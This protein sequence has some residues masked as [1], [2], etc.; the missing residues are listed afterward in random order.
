MA[1]WRGVEGKRERGLILNDEKI[2]QVWAVY[3]THDKLSSERNNNKNKLYEI[4]RDMS[5]GT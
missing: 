3:L 1:A 2:P 4:S 5:S